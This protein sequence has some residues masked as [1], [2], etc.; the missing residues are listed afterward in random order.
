M[1]CQS[2]E[3]KPWRIAVFIV[4]AQ[5]NARRTIP[6]KMQIVPRGPQMGNE[7]KRYADPK[8]QMQRKSNDMLT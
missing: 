4:S 6:A 1:W 3:R 8:Q 7:V 5:G 2:G